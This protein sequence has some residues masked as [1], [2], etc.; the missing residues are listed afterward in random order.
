MNDIP[1]FLSD[2]WRLSRPYFRSE[3]KWSAWLLLIAIIALNLSMVGMSVVLNFWNRL[4]FNSLQAKNYQAFLELLFTWRRTPGGWIMPGFCGVVVVYIVVS[5]YATYLNQWLQIRWRRWLTGRFLDEWLADRAYYRISL[6]GDT[7]TIGTDNPDQRIAEDIRDFVATT[8]SLSVDFL[9]NIVSFVSFV[10][11]L[12]GLS[13]E[14][15]LLGV[16][17]PGYMVWVALA[18]A[19]LGTWLTHL[20]GR[21]LVGL[22]FRQQRVEADFRY[23]LVRLR[24]NVEGVAL[25]SGEA[26]EKTNLHQRFSGVIGNWWLI[27]R[28]TKLLNSLIAGYE[29]VAVV[30]PIIVAAP[31]YFAGQ[32][33]LGGLTQTAGAFGR[34]QDSLSWFVTAYATLAGWRATVERLTSFHRAIVAAR[35]AYGEGVVLADT[36]TETVALRD[37]NL[38]LPN[39]ASLLKHADLAF[40]KG[41][42]VVVT[43]RSGSGK[44]TLFRA[45]AGIWPFGTGRIERPAARALFLPQRPYIPLGTLR[46]VVTYPAPATRFETRDIA[47]ALEDAGLTG[48]IGQLDEDENWPQRLSGGE[49]QRIA[50]A[51]ALLARP[52]WLFLDEATAS[53]D[54]ESE[55]E[56]YRALKQRLPETTI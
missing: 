43:G 51:R 36:S 30:F 45:I 10:G 4:F 29:Q 35:M 54:P 6:A 23:A 14:I 2:V 33:P 12:W 5:I 27:M 44:S 37:I 56:L 38:E 53:L 16:T 48:L 34:V 13:G 41:E 3:E 20:V 40:R 1:T 17:V 9:S 8:L 18:Y 19:A 7:G 11:I 46:H 25:Y 21:P 47:Q 49:Q 32:L 39:G 52:D 42:S 15:T 22:R 31:R 50:L 24:E 55:A 26:E 28:R